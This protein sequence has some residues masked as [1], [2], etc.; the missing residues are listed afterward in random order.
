MHRNVAQFYKSIYFGITY[1]LFFWEIISFWSSSHYRDNHDLFRIF[2]ILS[3]KCHSIVEV[4]NLLHS[5]VDNQ[6]HSMADN[7]PYITV[8]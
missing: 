8:W 4:D 3:F 5:M 7:D 1:K 2:L 6:L